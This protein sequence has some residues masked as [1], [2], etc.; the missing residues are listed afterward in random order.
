VILEAVDTA[1]FVARARARLH[2]APPGPFNPTNNP[3]GDHSLNEP[4]P[5][6]G[7]PPKAAAVLIPVVLHPGAA[8][9]LLTQRTASLRDHSGQIAFPGG[10]VDA[11][12][13]APL[14]TALREAEEEIGLARDRVEPLGYLDA[15]LTGTNYF[16]TPVVGLVEPGFTLALNPAEVADA[17]EVPL[18]LLLDRASYELHEREWKGQRRRFYAIPFGTRTIWGATAGILRNLTDRLYGS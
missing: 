2:V 17:F 4:L 9:V 6:L 18:G 16:I 13:G 3:R 12:D 11:E 7:A 8:T 10:K 1:D 5:A 15:Y 14:V